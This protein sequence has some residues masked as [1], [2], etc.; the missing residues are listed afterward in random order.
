M[1]ITDILNNVL[2]QSGFLEKGSFFNS[3]DP[4]DKQMVAISNRVAYEIMN[5]YPWPEL[6]S[7]FTVNMH[8]GQ[9]RYQLPSDY[10]SLIPNSAWETDGS[11]MVEFPVPDRRWFMYKFTTFSDGG[12][13]RVRKYGDALEVHD[14][15]DGES[16]EFEYI[17]N[18]TMV[19]AQGAPKTAFTKDDDEFILDDQLLVLGIQAHWQQS[20]RM[21][22]YQ[23]HMANYR[24]KTNEAI[25]RA[26]GS[27]TIGGGKF[28]GWQNSNAPFYPL[29]RKG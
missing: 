11:R 20:K 7:S 3:A 26:A 5:F 25:G 6:R 10:Q 14:P 1:I 4:D 23:E 22:S 28:G 18:S 19:D 15:E 12:T 8:A 29:Y 21:P 13:I 17:K 2:A 27:R 16:F 24:A 9:P